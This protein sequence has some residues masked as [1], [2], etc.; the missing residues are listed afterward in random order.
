MI[1]SDQRRLTILILFFATAILFVVR[2]FFIQIIDDSYVLSSENQALRYVK[3]FAARGIIYDRNGKKIVY[4]EA[5]YDLMVTPRLMNKDF[6]TTKFCL[7]TQ[8][9]HQDFVEKMKKARSYSAY[10]S[11][12]F[13]EQLTLEQFAPIMEK[14]HLFPAFDVQVRSI[15]KIPYESIAHLIG[16]V[17]EVDQNV[18]KRD[19]SYEEGDYIG[20]IGI[21]RSYEQEL[22][23]ENGYK[24]Y[25][26]NSKNVIKEAYKDGKNDKSSVAGKVLKLGIDIDLQE[27]AYKLM[28][29]KKGSVVAIDPKTGE[30]L[31]LVSSP[32]YNPNLL[33][34][35]D[36]AKNY[37]SLA[38]N[39]T[40]NPLFNR[41]LMAEY[42]P[43][44]TFK[45]I[46][47]LI[48]LQEG[49]MSEHT[50]FPCNKGLVGCHDHPNAHNLREAIRY[51]CNPYFYNVFRNILD[52]PG[53]IFY[54]HPKNLDKWQKHVKSF[55]L[56]EKLGTDLWGERKG[57]IPGSAFYNKIYGEH[58]WAFTTIYSL[59]I[60]QGEI[61]I[62]PLQM[63]H[64]TAV[65]ANQGYFYT[66]HVVK[67]VEGQG[68]RKEFTQKHKTS[69]DQKHFGVIL[70]GMRQV[71]E[72]VGGTA[73]R[74]RIKDVQV[75]GK[76]GTAQNPHGEDHSIFIAFAPMND[77][78]IAISV[79][80]ENAGFGG[81]WAAPIAS[82]V[83][84]K[85]LNGTV[86]DTVK[87]NYILEKRFY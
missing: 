2:L 71:V 16:Y 4:N 77:P 62:S 11:T 20:M 41:A 83:M 86:Q 54:K 31:A 72:E 25:I 42:P 74:A 44:S 43:G 26:A 32:S 7:L 37:Q 36:R 47:A 21:E 66:P 40:L 65:I 59:S 49:D 82:L 87:E 27:Y 73:G 34:G 14:L 51:S 64:M 68:V 84:E 50:G 10:K 75:C 9:E 24:I 61:L 28:Q 81:T 45:L 63:T 56:G 69:I 38:R 52:E 46:Q 1:N 8:I 12:L 67:D 70:E 13:L 85:Y 17:G 6:D 35:R 48:A 33:V 3:Q 19:S 76:T 30:I 23:G 80:I 29:G 18:I 39:D 78:K 57:K 15:R 5:V 60:G 22:R 58:R 55:G 79:Y 53:S